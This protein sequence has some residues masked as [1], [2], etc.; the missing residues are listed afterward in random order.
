MKEI[1]LRDYYPNY[2]KDMFVEVPD[3]VALIL[4]EYELLEEAYRIRTYRHKAFY[5]LEA[6]SD[7][8]GSIRSNAPTPFEI[9]EEKYTRELLKEAM[10]SL[11]EKQ[12]RRI[13]AHYFLGMSKTEIAA[14]EHTDRSRITR[15]IQA[16][17]NQLENF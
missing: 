6:E 17:L 2:T 7:M 12:R 10:G 9:L 3:E 16:G 8:A 15:S 4:R 13:Y 14:A 5:S 1:N 11:P